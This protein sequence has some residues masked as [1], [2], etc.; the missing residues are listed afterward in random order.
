[1]FQHIRYAFWT[2]LNSHY[3]IAIEFHKMDSSLNPTFSF[4]NLKHPDD[5]KDEETQLRIRRLAMTEVG[6]ARRKPKTKRGR[7]EIVLELRNT[8]ERQPDFDR[9]GSGPIDPFS[10]YPIE[11]DDSSRTLLANSKYAFKYHQTL[12]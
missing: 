1:V 7:N 6:K 12:S 4:I 5:L 9:L 3:S 10:H 11:L 2:D 8:A